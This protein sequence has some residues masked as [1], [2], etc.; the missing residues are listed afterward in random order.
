MFYEFNQNNS[1]GGFDF[2]E[3]AGITHYVIVEA[4]S[5]D[6]ANDRAE[7]I[8]LY[9]EGCESGMD[10]PCC[11][12]RWS[13]VWTWGDREPGTEVPT[14]YDRPLI[15]I[16]TDPEGLDKWSLGGWMGSNPEV[17]VHLKDGRF[18]GFHLDEQGRY[19]Y[20]GDPSDLV[21][22]L[23]SASPKAIES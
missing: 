8:G 10:C 12:D 2:D 23:P 5:A 1:G 11:G 13:R 6:D 18:F 17:F 7:R 9:F 4:D 19:V 3:K 16:G 21:E 22:A 15:E 14:L 20:K